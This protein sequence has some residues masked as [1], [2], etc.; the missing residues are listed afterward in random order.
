MPPVFSPIRGAQGFQQ[1]NP[2]ILAVAALLASLEVFKEAGMMQPIRERSIVLTNRLEQ[3]LKG[4][5]WF[6]VPEE[7]ERRTSL[8]FTIITPANQ[9]E[10]GAQ[11]SLLMLPTGRK[12]MPRI[13]AR[14]KAL[15]VIG[16]EREPDVIRL[17][18][19]AL[20]NNEEEVDGAVET[21]GKALEE[22]NLEA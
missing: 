22:M 14:L 10:R 21:L 9:E 12:V 17:A 1:S 11:L 18:P 20:Y 6:V 16:D 3:G 8:G 19:I 13:F 4:L 5:K 2:C 7:A 15:G